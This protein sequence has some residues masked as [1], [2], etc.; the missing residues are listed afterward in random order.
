MKIQYL[1]G[2]LANQVF[3]YIFVRYAELTYPDC[4]PWIFDDSFFLLRMCTMAMNWTK[5]LILKQI[6]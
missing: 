3:Q 4:G 6:Y 1:N 2:G 5:F